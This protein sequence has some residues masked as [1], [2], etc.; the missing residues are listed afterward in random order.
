LKLF[1][2]EYSVPGVAVSIARVQWRVMPTSEFACQSARTRWFHV[3]GLRLHALEWGDPG[4]PG[5]CFL[6]GGAA[7]AH[8]FDWVA[9]AFVDR[10][11]V[12]ALDQRGHGES[13]WPEPPAYGTEE[14]VGDLVAVFDALGWQQV[15]LVGHSMG[16]HNSIGCSAWHP[17]RVRALVIV[18]SRPS[19]PPDRLETMHDRGRRELKKHPTAEEAE[20]RF[21]L[22]PRET[23]ADPALLAHIAR[24]GIVERAGG[25]AYR[26][27]PATYAVRRPVDGWTLVGR[28][29]AP[30][31]IAKAEHSLGLPPAT[32]AR[33]RDAIPGARLVEIPGAHHHITL[34]QPKPFVDALDTFLRSV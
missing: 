31:L 10:F 1:E 14:F 6:H 8:W 12:I 13:A 27:D 15:T 11:H 4:R 28:I 5:L 3:N 16:G 18:D 24:A 26:F 20:A 17:D 25:W 34:D 30:T 22:L 33:L 21:R 19:I 9:P 23:V 7:H 2:I 29:K 32:A